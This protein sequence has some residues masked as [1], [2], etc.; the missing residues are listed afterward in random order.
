MSLIEGPY[1][2][3]HTDTHRAQAATF[4]LNDS[5]S[6]S[7]T[8]KSAYATC[9][10]VIPVLQGKAY[11]IITFDGCGS[12]TVSSNAPAAES[13]RAGYRKRAL[14][15]G[16]GCTNT[17]PH[18]STDD[19]VAWNQNDAIDATVD[20]IFSGLGDHNEITVTYVEHFTNDSDTQGNYLAENSHE[21][22]W[23]T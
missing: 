19:T 6:N 12:V 21:Q 3:V 7:R 11:Q 8:G 23:Y 17:A 13:D 14:C 2:V 9:Q 10:R 22:P 1:D 4:G 15:F 20:H 5:Q 16:Q 18:A